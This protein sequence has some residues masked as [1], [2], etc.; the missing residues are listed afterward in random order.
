LKPL[1][2]I[3]ATAATVLLLFTTIVFAADPLQIDSQRTLT[4]FLTIPWCADI[5]VAEKVMLARPKTLYITRLVKQDL[6]D[7]FDIVDRDLGTFGNQTAIIDLEFVGAKGS[8]KLTGG[9]AFI[10]EDEYNLFKLFRAISQALT[11][12][13][14]KPDIADQ[15]K[16]QEMKSK[17]YLSTNGV[18]S[19]IVMT[20]KPAADYTNDPDVP[21]YLKN[22]VSGVAIEYQYADISAQQIQDINSSDL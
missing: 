20:I 4:G 18:P 3:I 6:P 17:W 13:Y 19:S 11:S 14:G 15:F 9:S 1:K 8:E 2:T 7:H 10:P 5:S 12:K 22:T 16:L 21:A